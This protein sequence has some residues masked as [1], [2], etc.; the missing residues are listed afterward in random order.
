MDKTR[1][2]Y[3]TWKNQQD[4]L[5]GGATFQPFQSKTHGAF[6]M[7]MIRAEATS[8]MYSFAVPISARLR[9][10]KRKRDRDKHIYFH[11]HKK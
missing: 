5:V 9:G 1:P 8:E 10:V 4:V 3:E 6:N 2:K 7:Q 11:S